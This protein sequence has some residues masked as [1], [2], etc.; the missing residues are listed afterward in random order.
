M[1]GWVDGGKNHFKDWLQQSKR[2]KNLKTQNLCAK[3]AKCVIGLKHKRTLYLDIKSN[4]LFQAIE[5]SLGRS[6]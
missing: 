5:A 3:N 6:S 1:D 4:K 2:P